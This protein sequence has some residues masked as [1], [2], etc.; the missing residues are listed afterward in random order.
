MQSKTGIS[1][2]FSIL[3]F[4]S[5]LQAQTRLSIKE[6]GDSTRKV[7][8]SSNDVFIITVTNERISAVFQDRPLKV[9][10]TEE[11]ETYVKDNAGTLSSAHIQVIS[12]PSVKPENLKAV[13]DILT[14]HD[15]KNV[16]HTSIR[17]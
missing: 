2:L 12:K 6:S 7:A 1:A 15:L 17:D 9:A 8:A 13:M 5:A 10:T 11:L 3:I 16:L 4:C 14:K